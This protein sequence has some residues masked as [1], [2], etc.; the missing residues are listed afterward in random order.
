MVINALS[1]CLQYEGNCCQRSNEVR[2]WRVVWWM[3]NIETCNDITA[4]NR[5]WDHPYWPI[6]HTLSWFILTLGPGYHSVD[7]HCLSIICSCCF[8]I[9]KLLMALA[10]SAYLYL[11]LPS[12]DWFVKH[13]LPSATIISR[14]ALIFHLPLIEH[15]FHHHHRLITTLTH[16]CILMIL[17]LLRNRISRMFLLCELTCL[18][19]HKKNCQDYYNSDR[20]PRDVDQV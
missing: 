19:S 20:S 18:F 9:D 10:V 2:A 15:P 12:L 4:V 16:A 3:T 14:A 1:S 7:A 13:H 5:Y 11:Q 6:F 8:P 17:R